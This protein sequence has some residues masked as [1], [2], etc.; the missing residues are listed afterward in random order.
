MLFTPISPRIIYSAEVENLPSLSHFSLFFLL[1]VT[2]QS[3]KGVPNRVN[4]P[5]TPPLSSVYTGNI[6]PA[7]SFLHSFTSIMLPFD[8]TPFVSVYFPF[9]FIHLPLSSPFQFLLFS[10][11][12]CSVCTRAPST[13]KMLAWC[14]AVYTENDKVRLD[15][16]MLSFFLS[17]HLMQSWWHARTRRTRW[18]PSHPSLCLNC[19][20]CL[21]QQTCNMVWKQMSHLK[22]RRW[23]GSWR[24]GKRD[25]KKPTTK[26]FHLGP[27]V[28]S[29]YA[30]L[31]SQSG[32]CDC[33][34]LKT[35]GF[36]EDGF[37]ALKKGQ[38]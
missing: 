38:F 25:W 2:D 10:S 37:W 24:N 3:C 17:P 31:Q 15:A 11:R 7:L 27:R 33:H 8:F 6:Y 29:K 21:C 12:D 36:K 5:P 23:R 19:V 9:V 26:Y 22:T 32:T 16:V 28:L 13:C 4:P 14:M 18:A 34:M 35:L 1:F 20:V 30:V